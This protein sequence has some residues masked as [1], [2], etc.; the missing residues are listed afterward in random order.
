[1]NDGSK[2]P[3]MAKTIQTVREVWW[4]FDCFPHICCRMNGQTITE[5]RKTEDTREKKGMKITQFP[6]SHESLLGFVL[7]YFFV[8]LYFSLC[9][10][11][12]SNF[13]YFSLFFFVFLCLPLSFLVLLWFFQI[14]TRMIFPNCTVGVGMLGK[15]F[16]IE[17]RVEHFHPVTLPRFE[18]RFI[19]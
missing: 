7:R 18:K 10:F 19:H 17:R 4:W 3:S 16:Q 9:S 1:M 6:R 11:I 5:K 12:F 8:F 14:W 13:F 2:N 15:W